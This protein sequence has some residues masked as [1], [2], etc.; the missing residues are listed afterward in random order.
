MLAGELALAIGIERMRL[1]SL[2]VGPV[3]I[4]GKDIVGAQID[5]PRPDAETGGGDVA[6]GVAVELHGPHRIARAAVHIGHRS[7]VDDDLRGVV[8]DQPRG[9]V[10]VGEVAVLD[11]HAGDR[12][13]GRWAR[14]QFGAQHTSGAGNER[15]HGDSSLGVRVTVRRAGVN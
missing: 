9:N 15:A 7:A 11:V 8:G 5:E 4:A 2:D 6:G 1:V 13:V 3:E 10:P 12:P 14:H